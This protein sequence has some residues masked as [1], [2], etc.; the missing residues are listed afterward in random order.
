MFID[1]LLQLILWAAGNI[2]VN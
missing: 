2:T 1:M